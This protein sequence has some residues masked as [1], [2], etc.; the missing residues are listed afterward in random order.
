MSHGHAPLAVGSELG[1]HLGQTQVVVE[2]ASRDEGMHERAGNTLGG[3]TGEEQ[4]VGGHGLATDR[5]GDAALCVGDDCAV[6]DHG[7]LEPNL[8]TVRDELV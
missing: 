5:I 8:I 6:L 3:R 4:R 1:P 7:G 2:P